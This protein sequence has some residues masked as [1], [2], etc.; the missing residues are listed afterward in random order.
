[1]CGS[2]AHT[3]RKLRNVSG[4][5]LATNN[6]NR[7]WSERIHTPGSKSSR[8]NRF[9]AHCVILSNEVG[10]TQSHALISCLAFDDADGGEGKELIEGDANGVGIIAEGFEEMGGDNR[11][12]GAFVDL[13][14]EGIGYSATGLIVADA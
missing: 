2:D 5:G 14:P 10:Q 6:G 7:G 12:E 4:L 1:V 9:L 8:F 13:A 3:N 11:E